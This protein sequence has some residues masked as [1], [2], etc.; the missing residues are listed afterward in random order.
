MFRLFPAP[1]IPAARFPR[2]RG[3]VPDIVSFLAGEIPVF[4]AC[5]GMFPET[6]PA[7]PTTARFPR[8]RGD[9]PIACVRSYLS[10]RFSPRARGC[11]CRGSGLP[12]RGQVF[13]A[14]AG[15]FRSAVGWCS[16]P[17]CFPRVRGDV[18]ISRP[19]VTMP[20]GFSPRARGCSCRAGVRGPGIT[21]FPAC[22][23]MFLSRDFTIPVS[24]GFPACA[25]MFLA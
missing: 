12:Q 15:M 9:V 18:P 2:V 13:P 24:C 16:T 14:C 20:E 25:G 8:V 7:Y 22:A 3:D 10:F 5:A 4:P 1:P 11:S 19:V 17:C 6:A 23:G 21:V